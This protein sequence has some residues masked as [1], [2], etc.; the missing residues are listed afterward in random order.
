MAEMRVGSEPNG[1]DDFDDVEWELLCSAREAT[2]GM[3]PAPV[4][5]LVPV[6]PMVRRSRPWERR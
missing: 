3:I 6:L 4:E 5:Q 1:G 2:I